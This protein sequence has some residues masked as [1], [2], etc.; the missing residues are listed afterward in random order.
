MD[1]IT[2]FLKVLKQREC[3]FFLSKVQS[4]IPTWSHRAWGLES[5][6][7]TALSGWG[8]GVM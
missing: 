2:K 4:L 8:D 5:P 3:L 6:T 1:G 7:Q